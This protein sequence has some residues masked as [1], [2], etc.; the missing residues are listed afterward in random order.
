MNKIGY[1][2]ANPELINLIIYVLGQYLWLHV[3]LYSG[4]ICLVQEETI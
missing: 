3:Q 1:A 4:S 2:L